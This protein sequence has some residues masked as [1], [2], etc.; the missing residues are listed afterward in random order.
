MSKYLTVFLM[1]AE[2]VSGQ[3]Y[4]SSGSTITSTLT[5]P[6]ITTSTSTLATATDYSLTDTP[7]S[8]YTT[9]TF[10]YCTTPTFSAIGP[11]ITIYNTVYIDVCPTGGLTQVT[12]TM[13]DTC[14]CTA[15]T[16]YTRPTGCPSGF[17]TTEKTCTMC[18]GSPVI[19]CTSPIITLASETS[20]P[21]TALAGSSQ[22]SNAQYPPNSQNPQN[23]QHTNSGS[24]PSS[25][26]GTK[27]SY[28]T[29]NNA[30]P[31][32]SASLFG[33]IM[34]MSM[35]VIAGLMSIL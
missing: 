22:G 35:A 29:T 16:D 14:G 23:P 3:G 2:V 9:E 18:P 1:V 24:A 27:P 19:T 17:T 20:N 34:V 6:P 5:V 7:A 11:F 26:P 21:T 12:Y 30:R 33:L 32:A 10:Y 15:E 25:A 28:L 4:T 13:T 31:V 8:S